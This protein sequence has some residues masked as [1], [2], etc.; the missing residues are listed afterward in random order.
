LADS[1]IVFFVQN[2]TTFL[3]F[4]IFVTLQKHFLHTPTWVSRLTGVCLA[5]L[6][7]G[8]NAQTMVD[9][10]QRALTMY[11]AILS[12]QA[13]ADA[14]RSDIA[15]ARSAHYPQI[16]FG[17][18]RNSFS[19]G[20]VPT[21]IGTN[22]LSPTAKINLWSGGRIE[23]DAERSEALTLA[24]ELQK[25][26][27]LDDVALLAAESY[28][29]WAR[30]ADL[31]S[32]AVRNLESHRVTL[33]DIRKIVAVDTGRRIDY[34]QA[35]VRMENASITLAQRKADLAQAM[36]K[37]ARFWPENLAARPEKLDE[38]AGDDGPLG[39]VPNSVMQTINMVSDDLPAIAQQRANVKA[40]E[41]A[42]KY[43]KG[44]Y[45]PTVDLSMNRQF[46][47]N[48]LRQETFTQLSATMPVYNG[49]AASAQVDAANSQLKAAQF[50]LEEARMLARE[51]AGLSW[52]EWSS[53]RSR[54]ALGSSQS[55]MGDKVVEG[56]R[57][58]FRLAR[59]SLL[60]LLNIQNEAFTYQSSA[61]AAFHDERTARARL[62]A[63]T[64]ELANRFSLGAPP[65]AV[66]ERTSPARSRPAPERFEFPDVSN[67]ARSPISR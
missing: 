8:S 13:K 16:G 54:T 43:A 42:V 2:S 18:N 25:A 3:E 65:V 55:F 41:A 47:A 20:S 4:L 14:A 50:A 5:C 67:G 17:I 33:E 40:A 37:V 53:A 10:V 35:L 29:N 32:L 46:N 36:Q 7:G 62:L 34:E 57:A 61:R 38:M 51:K 52:Q 23:A 22:V 6:A 58:Q 15:R 60:D 24:S 9:V 63:A 11:P 30:T 39:K 45:W 66:P 56:Y 21:S 19:S 59:R 31:Y 12:A 26:A 48:T 64:G 49:G 44:N 27:T 28:L 1:Q